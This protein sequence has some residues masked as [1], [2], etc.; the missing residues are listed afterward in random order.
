MKIKKF[1]RANKPRGASVANH[2]NRGKP[3]EMLIE[4]SNVMYAHKGWA[5]IHKAEPPVKVAQK[6]GNK[7]TLGWYQ[8]QGFVDYFGVSNGRAIAFEAKTTNVRTS[9]PLGNIE[10][11]QVEVLERW[12][13]HG[14]ITF[15]LIDFEKHDEVYLLW[16]TQLEEWW[17]A[18]AEGG[19]KSIPYEWFHINCD[20][21]KSQRG[22]AL[23]Y[24]YS[25]KLPG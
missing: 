24:L 19:R 12:H 15:L 5:D 9:F 1:N 13:H 8:K 4:S 17:Q 18:A 11:H 16:Y 25:L 7:I 6:V 21:V 23:D 10:A 3:L 20:L 2:A 22:V 14:A